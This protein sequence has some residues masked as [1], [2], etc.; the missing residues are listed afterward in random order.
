MSSYS[1]AKKRLKG[2]IVPFAIIFLFHIHTTSLSFKKIPKLVINSKMKQYLSHSRSAGDA[3]EKPV[4]VK[5]QK[6]TSWEPRSPRIPKSLQNVFL[7]SARGK[8]VTEAPKDKSAS[9]TFKKKFGR[10]AKKGVLHKSASLPLVLDESITDKGEPATEPTAHQVS[11][12]V[13]WSS[14]SEL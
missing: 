5:A 1:K 6:R 12:H 7:A 8:E 13:Y 14:P 4:E 2:S 9:K 11:P 3:A 10:R